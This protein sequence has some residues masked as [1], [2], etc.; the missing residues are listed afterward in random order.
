MMTDGATR[1]RERKTLSQ[2]VAG[3]IKERI[4][5]GEFEQGE[6]IV[7]SRL[8]REVGLSLTPVREAVREL[9]GEGILTVMP[10]RGPSVRILE[11]DDAFELYTLRAQL[12]GLAIR[13]AIRRNSIPARQQIADILTDMEQQ[14]DDPAV[15]S[16]HG[17][18]RRIHLGIVHLS[19]HER[20]IALYTSLDLQ[21]ALLDR[22]VAATSSKQHEVDWHRPLIDVL[23]GDDV[24]RAQAVIMEHIR[25]SYETYLQQYQV[26]QATTNE[27]LDHDWM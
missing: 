20:L 7:E 3:I 23:L 21:V 26:R 8:A 22:L 13:L 2:E 18:S 16:L 19:G 10:N 4:R 5:S 15:T 9:V 24:D 6:R 1:L 12:E 11:P 17:A 14:A 27:S 25:E